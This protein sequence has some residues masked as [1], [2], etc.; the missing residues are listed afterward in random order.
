VAERGA[1]CHSEAVAAAVHAVGRESAKKQAAQWRSGQKV[2]M[3]ELC[4]AIL[5]DPNAHGQA[6]PPPPSPPTP[7]QDNPLCPGLSRALQGMVQARRALRH[8]PRGHGRRV[9]A[10]SDGLRRGRGRGAR[11]GRGAEAASAGERHGS[12]QGCDTGL[13]HSPPYRARKGRESV[14]RG[15][16]RRRMVSPS[17]RLI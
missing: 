4:E 2:Y 5:E 15:E 8:V 9:R 10:A 6:R 11:Q 12:A 3:A 1:A 16:R 7:S 13:P 14:E 17:G